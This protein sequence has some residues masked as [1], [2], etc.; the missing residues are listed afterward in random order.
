M[1]D[2]N[3]DCIGT[4]QA[5]GI[6]K[7]QTHDEV[8]DAIIAGFTPGMKWDQRRV[9]HS[10]TQ[11]DEHP[12]GTQFCM[13]GA[14]CANF[15][16]FPSDCGVTPLTNLL[17]DESISEDWSEVFTR[18]SEDAAINGLTFLSPEQKERLMSHLEWRSILL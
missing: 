3:C 18:M 7:L 12:C 5:I 17:L 15:G 14:I 4:A 13:L 10:G 6:T 2:N 11:S 1:Y 9:T 16:I 8:I